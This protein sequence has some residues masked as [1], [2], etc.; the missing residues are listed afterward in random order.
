VSSE[1]LQ[2]FCL[3]SRQL[4]AYWTGPRAGR[5]GQGPGGAW[6]ASSAPQGVLDAP[7][8]EPIIGRRGTGGCVVVVAAGPMGSSS[9]GAPGCGH[10]SG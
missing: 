5:A 9:A 3:C 10:P 2:V 1:V 6:P 7:G 8:C 4:E